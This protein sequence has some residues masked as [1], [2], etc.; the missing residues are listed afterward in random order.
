MDSLQQHPKDKV[1]LECP[2]EHALYPDG[3]TAGT[4]YTKYGIRL[5]DKTQLVRPGY[6][7]R[8]ATDFMR[9]Q[10]FSE[11]EI[12]ASRNNEIALCP[13]YRLTE[14]QMSAIGKPCK[15]CTK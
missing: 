11:A 10:G 5:L 7:W 4:L 6:D 1:M 12:R 2:H 13:V 3:I 14:Q 8:R 15:E 9:R